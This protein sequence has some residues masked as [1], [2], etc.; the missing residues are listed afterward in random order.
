MNYL[1][2]QQDI[3][4]AVWNDKTKNDFTFVD[5]IIN[6]RVWVIYKGIAIYSIPEKLCF[7]DTKAVENWANKMPYSRQ[8]I[9]NMLK[10]AD[11]GISV[12]LDGTSI[13]SMNLKCNRYENAETGL[14]IYCDVKLMKYSEPEYEQYTAK[15]DE[16][17]MYV[18]DAEEV[19]A[20]ILP[21]GGFK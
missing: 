1:K 10:G 14:K 16:R 20:V 19:I 21:I 9:D 13:N 6:G 4:K 5:T 2:L 3:I 12:R 18:K 11:A 7:I 17:V 8:I 15:D